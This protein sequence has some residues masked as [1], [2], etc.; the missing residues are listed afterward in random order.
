[1]KTYQPDHTSS[2]PENIVKM[3]AKELEEALESL[4]QARA[5][6]IGI[7]IKDSTPKP[8]TPYQLFGTL[9]SWDDPW[10]DDED[11]EEELDCDCLLCRE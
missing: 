4:R 2:T 8:T 7:P 10:L 6:A 9:D 1:M 3:T 11:D 5:Q